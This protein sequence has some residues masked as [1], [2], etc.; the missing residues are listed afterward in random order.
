ML[1]GAI[2]LAWLL[3]D[4][5]AT[6]GVLHHRR[7]FIPVELPTTGP[8]TA[9]LI[10][11]KGVSD[12]TARFLSALRSLRYDSYRL[13]FAVE[14]A[15]DEAFAVVTQFKHESEGQRPVDVVVAGASTDRAQKVHNLLAALS[16][17]RKDDRIVVFADADVVPADTW[18]SQ[19]VRPVANGDTASSCGYRWQLPVKGDWPSLILA[20]ADLSV[21]TAAR[22]RRWNLC[23]GGSV[24]VARD[25]LEQLNLQREWARAASDDLTLT[26]ALRSHALRIYAPPFVLVPSPVSHDW[27]S[28]FR[29]M[30][31]QYLLIRIYAPRHWL[32]AASTLG[33]P[34][35]GAVLAIGLACRG[36][37]WTLALLAASV[38]LLQI[39]LSVRRSIAHLVL[40]PVEIP[41]ALAT[42]KFA[43]WAWPLVHSIH[44]AALLSSAVGRR[45]SWAG[46]RYEL[47]GRK[48]RV[49]GRS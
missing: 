45:F 31:R 14:S 2:L 9:V 36:H 5:L 23:W 33:I 12:T 4:V 7:A 40:S 37:W 25:A 41:T 11:I 43:R 49:L 10:A 27:A 24:A 20:A 15:D 17:L 29:F 13:I 34:A 32:F 48:A 39:R 35:L 44:L 3:T 30:H 46:I 28:L 6:Y 42:V 18:L 8:R 1:E 38:L 16:R 47:D 26:R 22:S 21:A 19:L